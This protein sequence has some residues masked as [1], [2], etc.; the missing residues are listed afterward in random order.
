MS[1][2][3]MG[4]VKGEQPKGREES[5]APAL[6]VGGAASAAGALLLL[7]QDGAQP[8]TDNPPAFAMA[9][10]AKIP[11]MTLRCS[12][13]TTR[14]EPLLNCTDWPTS[15]QPFSPTPRVHRVMP[16][17]A[18]FYNDPRMPLMYAIRAEG[19]DL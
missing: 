8:P 16:Y 18:G 15:A 7:A 10:R 6:V 14:P 9:M 2:L 4:C 17:P 19:V 5:V 11:T 13:A 3:H 1:R 12:C